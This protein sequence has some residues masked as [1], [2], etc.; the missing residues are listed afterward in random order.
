MPQT[1]QQRPLEASRLAQRGSIRNG[2]CRRA[3]TS[4]PSLLTGDKLDVREDEASGMMAK[5]EADLEGIHPSHDHVSCCLALKYKRIKV[6]AL[7]RCL[8]R[9]ERVSERLAPSRV[10]STWLVCFETKP[11]RKFTQQLPPF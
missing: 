4:G 9:A 6:V 11:V 2:E 5:D 10:F 1:T 8:N 3:S 7:E